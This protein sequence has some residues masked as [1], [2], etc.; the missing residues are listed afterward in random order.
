LKEAHD[1]NL[2]HRDIKPQ[3]VMV[4][5]LGGLFDMVKVLD[6]GLVKDLE[7]TNSEELTTTSEITGTPLYMSPERITTP[8][9]SD[10]R[11]DIYAVGALAYYILSAQPLF[12]YKNDL[13]VMY[14]IINTVPPSLKSMNKEVPDM[15]SNLVS[16]CLEKEKEDRPESVDFLM[17]IL[18][19]IAEEHPYTQEDAKKWWQRFKG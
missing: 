17:N 14:Q 8:G 11:S 2:I 1:L 9:S 7:K 19:Q 15:L 3:N 18:E 5:V 6:F 10:N 13:D 12:E 16:V 4:C